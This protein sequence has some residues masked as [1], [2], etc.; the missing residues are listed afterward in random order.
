MNACHNKFHFYSLNC[1]CTFYY[2]D[3]LLY[4]HKT[5]NSFYY[6]LFIYDWKF[7]FNDL[8]LEGG[9]LIFY[10]GGNKFGADGES[11]M[12]ICPKW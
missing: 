9:D 4:A 3:E 12:N 2:N 8:P 1:K 5:I 7:R 11:L 10:V 6:S